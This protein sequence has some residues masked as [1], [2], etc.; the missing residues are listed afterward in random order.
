VTAVALNVTLAQTTRAGFVTTWPTGIARPD[1]SSLNAERPDQSIANL[2]IV[3]LGTDGKVSLFTENG[4][5]L[6]ADVAGYFTDSTAKLGTDGLFVPQSPDRFLDTR[7]GTKPAANSTTDLTI[8][9]VR[10]VPASAVAAALNV[11][12]ANTTNPGFTE[13]GTHFIVDISGYYT[14]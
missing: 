2:V 7:P 8:A 4:T 12:L 5:H 11:T 6:V 9:G 14:G 13:A 1:T 10:G 3:P